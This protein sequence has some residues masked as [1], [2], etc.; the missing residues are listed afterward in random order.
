MLSF[1]LEMYEKDIVL[2]IH[3][4]SDLVRD[5]YNN[6]LLHLFNLLANIFT[7]YR[8]NVWHPDQRYSTIF[9][10]AEIV[11]YTNMYKYDRQ[12]S[13]QWVTEKNY[14]NIYTTN[15]AIVYWWQ[16]AMIKP[17][18]DKERNDKNDHLLVEWIYVCRID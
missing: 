12:E 9:I 7:I 14:E 16:K 11:R 15:C 6:R 1:T 5:I 17:R 4:H 18:V 2:I 13:T 8:K 3:I 10:C